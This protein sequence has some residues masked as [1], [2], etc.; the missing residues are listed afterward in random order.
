[1]MHAGDH[2]TLVLV[3][4]DHTLDYI[5][6]VRHDSMRIYTTNKAIKSVVHTYFQNL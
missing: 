4:I 3:N 1:M 6:K 2:T 5:H